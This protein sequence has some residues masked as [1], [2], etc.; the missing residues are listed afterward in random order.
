MCVIVGAQ[1]R[2]ALFNSDWTAMPGPVDLIP[3]CFRP[4]EIGTRK[5]DVRHS[6]FFSYFYRS[7]W[8]PYLPAASFS[9][10]CCSIGANRV[11]ILRCP[12]S[13]LNNREFQRCRFDVRYPFKTDAIFWKTNLVTVFNCRP[14][15]KHWQ[16]FS[17]T[18]VV[19]CSRTFIDCYLGER[20]WIRS[21][22][23]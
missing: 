11:P 20:R 7:L 2:L 12:A 18:V 21:A 4:F 22:H 13:M 6:S 8:A 17:T 9:S 3:R 14:G 19:F 5:F 10:L 15:R 1:T 16:P 23:I